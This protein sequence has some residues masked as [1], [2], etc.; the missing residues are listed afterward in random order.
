MEASHMKECHKIKKN[1]KYY[2]HIQ[3]SSTDKLSKL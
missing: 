3:S 1:W 2:I